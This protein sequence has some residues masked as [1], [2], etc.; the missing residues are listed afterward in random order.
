VVKVGLG[1]FGRAWTI[2]GVRD[3]S[4]FPIFVGWTVKLARYQTPRQSR[5][6]PN[7]RYN[8][9]TFKKGL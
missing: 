8:P 3:T 5:C 2:L 7:L 6:A 4:W 9:D 1:T